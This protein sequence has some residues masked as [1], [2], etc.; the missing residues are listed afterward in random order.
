MKPFVIVDRATVEAEVGLYGYDSSNVFLAFQENAFMTTHLFELWVREMFFPAVAQRRAEVGY[1]ERALLLLDGLGSHHTDEF[2]QT[3]AGQ[4]IDV[5]FLVPHSS[6]QT[7]PLDVLTFALMKRHFS[8]SRS[9]RL[10][11]P[12]SNRPVRILGAWSESNA[13]HHN[14][15]GFVV[16]GLVPLE[17]PSRS[18]EYYLRVQCEAARCVRR[19]PGMEEGASP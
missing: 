13:P 1:T 16:I 6:D 9:S 3:C 11:N 10:E 7:Q 8:G 14:I 18:G 2:L 4:D 5:L 15:E 19:W 17:E 12:Q